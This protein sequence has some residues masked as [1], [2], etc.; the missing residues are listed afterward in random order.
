MLGKLAMQ[1]IDI[2]NYIEVEHKIH[3][4][5]IIG[6]GLAGF[7]L[8]TS[9]ATFFV[10]YLLSLLFGGF[11]ESPKKQKPQSKSGSGNKTAPQK[12]TNP[13]NAGA[14]KKQRPKRE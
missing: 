2:H 7:M 12:S 5:A 14:P 1:L 8:L 3:S 10:G 11:G 6:G 4:Y 9:L 13:Q